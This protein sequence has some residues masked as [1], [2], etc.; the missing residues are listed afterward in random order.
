MDDERGKGSVFSR[1]SR[2]T[3][4]GMDSKSIEAHE[5]KVW[6]YWTDVNNIKKYKALKESGRL[7]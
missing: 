1:F 4:K 2:K 3:L 6:E 7:G 5:T